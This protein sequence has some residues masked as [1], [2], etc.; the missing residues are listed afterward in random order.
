[1]YIYIYCK[2]TPS[3]A[4]LLTLGMKAR[5]SERPLPSARHLSNRALGISRNAIGSV[6]S[7]KEGRLCALANTEEG[8]EIAYSTVQDMPFDEL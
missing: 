6:S 3:A 2:C 8:S 5:H 7:S 1:M 4:K